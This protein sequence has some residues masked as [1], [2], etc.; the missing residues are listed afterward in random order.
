MIAM[1]AMI[2]DDRMLVVGRLRAFV[3]RAGMAH[4]D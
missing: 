1:I 2:G 3:V 4:P